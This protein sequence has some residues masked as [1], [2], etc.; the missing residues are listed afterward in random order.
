MKA[1]FLKDG[2]EPSGNSNL[3]KLIKIIGKLHQKLNLS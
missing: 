1:V 3:K 2:G